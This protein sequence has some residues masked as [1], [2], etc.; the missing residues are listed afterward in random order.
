[1]KKD[2]A[3]RQQS[4][5]HLTIGAAVVIALTLYILYSSRNYFHSL[6]LPLAHASTTP[7][8][9]HEYKGRSGPDINRVTNDT[10]GFSKIF[11]VGLKERTDRRDALALTSA[12][13]GFHVD[14][15]D[16]VRGSEI[17]G[18]AL[19][20]RVDRERFGD[21][22]LGSWRAHMNVIRRIVEDNLE[23]AL[24]MEDDVDW[25]VRLKS[26]LEQVA[27]GSRNIFPS[28]SNPNSPYG[29][30]WD[31]LWIGHCGELFPEDLD[32]NK[33]KTPYKK[34]L[35][36]DDMTVPPRD[37]LTSLIDFG[38]YPEHTRIVHVGAAPICTFAYA[39]SQRG[40]RKV[41]LDMSID[42][43]SGHYD[44]ALAQLCR[45]AARTEDPSALHAKCI[46]VT[47]PIMFHHRAKGSMGQDSDTIETEDGF[48][49]KG[50]TEDIVWSAR[51]N[52]RNMINGKKEMDSEY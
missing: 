27:R 19:P 13:T 41:L 28:G 31:V 1:M 49:E 51:N 35:I 25:D 45:N 43:L 50:F 32:E 37:K 33:G 23:S 15:I 24:I 39:L 30:D 16:G 14:W 48:R 9:G 52:I 29:D 34:F 22:M 26:Q 4:R 42:G 8:W 12:L 18:K 7:L 20:F 17:P 5:R 11:V 2:K 38:K 40:A 44:N 6:T 47:P 10:L 21:A 46:S 36:K 3:M